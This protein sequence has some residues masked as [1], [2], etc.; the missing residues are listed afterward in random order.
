MVGSPVN[1]RQKAK[2]GR[3]WTVLQAEEKEVYLYY[4]N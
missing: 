2:Q 1:S 4:E 3:F